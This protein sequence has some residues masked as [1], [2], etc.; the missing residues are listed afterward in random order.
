MIYESTFSKDEK[1]FFMREAL[2]EAKH[3]R[4]KDEVP[5]G[6]V[7]VKDKKII[8][9]GFNVRETTQDATTHAEM[10]A[11]R[12]ANATENSWRLENTALFVTVEPCA[13]CAGACIL[14]RIPEIYFGAENKK[15]G[16]A[17]TVMN[18]FDVDALNHAPFVEGG[19]LK[20]ECQDMMSSFFR[21]KRKLGKLRRQGKVIEE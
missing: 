14:S 15:G 2:N 5:I 10:N 9:R 7:I 19:V 12:S 16:M 8:A 11:I 3:A 6:C 21:E 13:M 1:E 18:L 17:G 4:E 20:E